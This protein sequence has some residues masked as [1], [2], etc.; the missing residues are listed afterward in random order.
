MAA[1]LN[2][3]E[4]D[5]YTEVRAFLRGLFSC[6]VIRAYSNN[7]PLPKAPF[8]LTNILGTADAATNE[9][10]YDKTA[11]KAGVSRA[12]AV[13]MQLDFYGAGSEE[14]CRIFTHLWRDFYTCEQLRQ[15]QP[16]YTDD[17]RFMPLSNEEADFEERW[18]VTAHLAYCPTVTH[19]QEY[20]RTFEI[21]LTQP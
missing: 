20:V 1:T 4:N 7:V 12:T 16:L 17:A 11:G 10:A 2:I 19:G 13:R 14:R 3:G 9:H 5:I 15:C 8:V 18:T 21:E 6:E